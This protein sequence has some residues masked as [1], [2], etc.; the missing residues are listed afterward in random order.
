[1]RHKR[2]EKGS[3]S[4]LRGLADG[5]MSANLMLTENTDN[6]SSIPRQS[7]IYHAQRADQY[8]RRDLI[9]QY[10]EEYSCRLVVMIDA[11]VGQGVTMFEEL[12]YDAQPE[13]NLHLLLH[14]PGVTARP[15]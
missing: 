8:A 9:R 15:P 1:M 12:I 11:I 3:P 6:S 10:G 2:H 5:R 7:P 14:S 4:R 13:E